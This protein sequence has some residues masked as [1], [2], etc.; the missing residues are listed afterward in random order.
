MKTSRRDFIKSGSIAAA[1][2]MFTKNSLFQ[3][4]LLAR[5]K[6]ILGIQ[7]YSVRSD[8][9]KDPVG[10]IEKLS[11]MGYRNVEHAG[12]KD[13]K[14]YGFSPVEFKKILSDQGTKM[15]SGHVAFGVDDWDASK[16]QFKDRWKHTIE[17][18]I[19]VGQEYLITPWMDE[20]I[21]TNKDTLNLLLDLFN[22]SGRLCNQMGI[23]FGYHNHD[24]EFNTHV[25]GKLLY[26]IIL[27]RMEKDLVI[28]QL[29]MGN[30][31]N[32]G[33]KPMDILRQY[34]GRFEIMHVKDEIKSDQ[35]EMGG[36]Y[37]STVLGK[38][39]LEVRK[40]VDYA[41]KKGGTNVFIVE[42]ESYQKMSRLETSKS[43]YEAMKKW[44]Y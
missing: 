44:G 26:D 43:N 19:T 32:A 7:L 38:G 14:F 5:K 35:G 17:D 12:Y 4:D 6:K 22:D 41:Y 30:M 15:I 33:A 11:A 25:D 8:M 13:R 37:E 24:F 27:E 40:V 23:K 29:D 39:V 9:A 36:D 2:L 31:Y 10:T 3:N 16:K 34:P 28:Q 42:Q 18:A 20:A 1:G 21:R